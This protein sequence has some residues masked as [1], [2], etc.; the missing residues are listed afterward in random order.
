MV[1]TD[2]KTYLFSGDQ[3]VGCT[4]AGYELADDG[5]PK[6]TSS[7]FGGLPAA[8]ETKID[9]AF[10][11]D[12]KLY[13]ISGE[14]YV[15]YSSTNYS[16]VDNSYPKNIKDGGQ[17]EG[18]W[19]DF[20]AKGKGKQPAFE[21]F[22]QMVCVYTDFYEQK[23]R[24][25]YLFYNE[26]GQLWLKEYRYTNSQYKWT[27]AKLVSEPIFHQ[28]S[29][30]DAA[31]LGTD[32]KVYFFSENQYAY[33]IPPSETLSTPT[34]INSKW[35]KIKNNFQTLE[36]V[37]AAYVAENGKTYLFCADQYIRYTMAINPS[38]AD[39]YVDEAYPKLIEGNWAN[40]GLN[41]QVPTH[42]EA[43]GFALCRDSQNKTYLFD[44]GN[45][46]NS[47]EPN[48][49]T[50]IP[51]RWGIVKNNIVASSRIDAAYRAE[52]NQVY[53]FC[54]DQYIRYSVAINPAGENFYVD[55]S[56]P[57]TIL[58]NWSNEGLAIQVPANFQPTG[59]A[60]YRWNQT[61]YCFA[62]THYTTSTDPA[63]KLISERWGLVKNQIV[64]LDRIDAAFRAANGKTYLFC[65]DQYIRYSMAIKPN[66]DDFYVDEGYPKTIANNWANEGF[67][68]QLPAQFE[69]TGFA[70]VSVGTMLYVFAEA[71]YKTS[72][73][74]QVE[75]LITERWGLVK[76]NI[77]ALNRIDAAYRAENDKTYLFCDDQYI[78]Y[79]TA[80]SQPSNADFYVDEGYPLK[81]A[82]NWA[83]EGLAIQIPAQL[84]ATGYALF[85]ETNP[86]QTYCFVKS[87]YY[88]AKNPTPKPVKDRW[89]L[90]RNTIETLNRV[91]AAYQAGNQKIW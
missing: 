62:Q 37:D 22:E 81:I 66:Q 46:K 11:W 43:E 74:P 18:P 32:N 40:E 44:K 52:N 7:V 19:F 55:E 8:F 34:L 15:R 58:N 4:G 89:G 73:T 31:F 85:Q 71:Y 23:K 6:K 14:Q 45:Y 64:E 26:K 36:R 17:S 9:A 67:N 20:L 28:F 53:L 78:R 12:N 50:P 56:Y 35:G 75:Q 38:Q 70:I 57:K 33:L 25:N 65:S 30:L 69:P 27:E 5:Y 29:T 42:F 39:F 48:V 83:N 13:F 79:S 41:I 80:I 88:E 47:G 54:G 84:A 2:N 51:E 63:A 61:T 76:N 1:S 10:V 3:V 49:V 68:F 86:P 87:S 82:D 77:A 24:I 59:F 91:D 16:Q 90:V 21:K 72:N 60:R